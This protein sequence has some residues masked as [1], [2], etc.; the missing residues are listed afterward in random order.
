MKRFHWFATLL[1]ALSLVSCGPQMADDAALKSWI[2]RQC[3]SDEYARSIVNDFMQ[4]VAKGDIKVKGINKTVAQQYERARQQYGGQSVDAAFE[5]EA[6]DI[7][8]EDLKQQGDVFSSVP[9]YSLAFFQWT[10]LSK[11][12]WKWGLEKFSD[13]LLDDYEKYLTQEELP[14]GNPFDRT[15]AFYWD[16]TVF[17]VS[18]IERFLF[19]FSVDGLKQLNTGDEYLEAKDNLLGLA[20]AFFQYQDDYA[21]E[22]ISILDW[23]YD[24][25]ATGL[26][27]TGYL[28]EYEI[29]EGYYVL[30]SLK[31]FDD[32]RYT[33]E[34]IYKGNSLDEM[35]WHYE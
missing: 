5:E 1:V 20:V 13:F 15:G 30:L 4:Q 14:I 21:E 33:Y 12:S 25:N 8:S 22:E 18:H 2:L 3:M 7:L 23:N 28:V 11:L 32:G 27:Y 31:E 35:L 19:A 24:V 9:F 6:F 17:K 34:I 16:G 10:T 29:G 26:A